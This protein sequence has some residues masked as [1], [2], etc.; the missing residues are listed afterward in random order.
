[1]VVGNCGYVCRMNWKDISTAPTGVLV[2][3][4]IDD[5]NGERNIQQMK[6]S[7]NL[8]WIDGLYVYYSPTHWSY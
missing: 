5:A 8:W 2:W 4:K 6:Y 3:T 7:Q 1:V